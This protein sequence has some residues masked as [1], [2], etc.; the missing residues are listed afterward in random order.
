[1]STENKIDSS[2]F[3]ITEQGKHVKNLV[4]E[5]V[6]VINDVP[7]YEKWV[8]RQVDYPCGMCGRGDDVVFCRIP[9]LNAVVRSCEN[10]GFTEIVNPTNSDSGEEIAY[11]VE[12]RPIT[13]TEAWA[14][15]KRFNQDRFPPM[16][17]RKE[18]R[19]RTRLSPEAL[20]GSIKDSE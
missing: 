16:G 8:F 9:P 3:P 11:N 10:C 2:K 19:R 13:I 15:V 7:Y 12:R 18:G 6:V 20:A 14:F 1:M 5:R 17:L 4:H